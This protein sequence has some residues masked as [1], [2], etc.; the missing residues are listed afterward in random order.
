M[1]TII[2]NGLQWRGCLCFILLACLQTA[3]VSIRPVAKIGLLAPFEGLYRRTGYTALA[4]MRAAIAETPVTGVDILP[5]ALDDGNDP[6][7][8]RRS[9][10]QLLADTSVQAV[11]GPVTPEAFFSVLA[12]L[13]TNGPLWLAPFARLPETGQ[14][15]DPRTTTAWATDL[16]STVAAAARRQHAQRLVLVGWKPGWPQLS[17]EAWTKLV[18]MP[19][20]VTDE[21]NA[22]AKTDAVFWLGNPDGAALYLANLRTVY[23]SV[24]FWLGPQ[25]G[26]P[27]FVER[28]KSRGPVYWA[29]WL[30]ADYDQWVMQH[31]D[32]ATPAAY[33][34]YQATRQSIGRLTN[35][36]QPL[37]A[38]AWRI[39]LFS[40]DEAGKSHPLPQ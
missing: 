29:T 1:R 14:T 13:P 10:Q 15:G 17:A 23:P 5:L 11:V 33:L 28:A 21:G 30:G 25:G 32:L 6:Q 37:A 36:T 12:V 9:A 7:R 39:Q 34:V 2:R 8:A 18:G 35:Q 31:P 27:V 22:L 24:P 3:C 40:I 38:P 19:V 20:L 16:V 26:D 4:A